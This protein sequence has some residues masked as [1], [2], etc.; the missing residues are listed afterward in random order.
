MLAD[1]GISDVGCRLVGGI[2]LRACLLVVGG[3]WLLVVARWVGI[4]GW[5]LVDCWWLVV[6]DR[7]SFAVGC[8]LICGCSLFVVE[9]WLDVDCGMWVVGSGLVTGYWLSV[10]RSVMVVVRWLRVAC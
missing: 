9:W 2:V 1:G 5:L 3:C 4:D 6:V 8:L 10:Y 7:W